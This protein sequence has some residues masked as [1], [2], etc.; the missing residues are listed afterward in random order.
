MAWVL[1]LVGT[2]S[3]GQAR[4]LDV[5]EISRPDN[6]R[7]VADL[8][9]TLYEAKQILAR[10]QQAAVAAQARGHAAL[11]PGICSTRSDDG[12]SV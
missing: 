2:G 12:L 9:L 7:D 10:G 4:G 3:D 11:R 8:G 1:R 5:M 6:L